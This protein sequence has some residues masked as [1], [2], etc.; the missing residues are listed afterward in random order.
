MIG[1]PQVRLLKTSYG[2]YVCFDQ[3]NPHHIADLWLIS[4]MA[5]FQPF[6]VIR[7]EQDI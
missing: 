2:R 1:G 6:Y 4:S 7:G 3:L 5:C